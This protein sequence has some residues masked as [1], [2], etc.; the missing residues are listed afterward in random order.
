MNRR[1]GF[2]S[3]SMIALAVLTL[4]LAM[5]TA[6]L[7]FNCMRMASLYEKKIRLRYLAESAALE[8]WQEVQQNPAPFFDGEPLTMPQ[9]VQLAEEGENV[10]I[11]GNLERGYLLAV[12]ADEAA[13]LEQSCYLF[14]EAV[15]KEDGA[16]ELRFIQYRE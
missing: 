5:T 12:A 1:N 3:F 2:F 9:S 7:S 14:F 10:T 11:E 6:L 13:Y 16:Y 4:S 15:L 8:G